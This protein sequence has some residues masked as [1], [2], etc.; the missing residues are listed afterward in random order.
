MGFREVCTFQDCERDRRIPRRY[1]HQV[2]SNGNEMVDSGL[3]IGLFCQTVDESFRSYTYIHSYLCRH[4]L[5]SPI[6]VYIY[7]YTYVDIH[8]VSPPI[9][10][11]SPKM[12]IRP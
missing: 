2:C 3:K 7:I 6:S 5:K 1:E 9:H 12:H 10:P 11:M 8:D 4:T